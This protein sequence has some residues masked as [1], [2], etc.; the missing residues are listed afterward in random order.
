MAAT[1]NDMHAT[2]QD[3]V[4]HRVAR[5]DAN[6]RASGARPEADTQNLV[7]LGCECTRVDCERLVK[8]PLY[9]YRRMLEADQYL[10]QAGHHA[11]PQYRTIISMGLMSIEERS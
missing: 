11:F 6:R 7:E 9:V 10:L 1:G 4:E 2:A 8:V 3:G 5:R